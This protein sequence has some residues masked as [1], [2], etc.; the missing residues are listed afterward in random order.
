MTNSTFTNGSFSNEKRLPTHR[1][2]LI[3]T[4]YTGGLLPIHYLMTHSTHFINGSF[5]IRHVVTK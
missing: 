3:W 4:E 5:S 1:Q 2:G